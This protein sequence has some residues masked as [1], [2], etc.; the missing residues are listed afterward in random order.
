MK[1][2]DTTIPSD[3]IYDKNLLKLQNK[4]VR[5]ELIAKE[6]LTMI[7]SM[8]RTKMPYQK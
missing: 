8:A 3:H 7:D 1:L 5:N 2:I 6:E 4:M